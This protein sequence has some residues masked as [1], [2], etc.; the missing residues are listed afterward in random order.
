MTTVPRPER[1]ATSYDVTAACALDTLPLLAARVRALLSWGRRISLATRW[2]DGDSDITLHPGLVV[3][4]D[5]GPDAVRES[6]K[7]SE[8]GTFSVQLAPGLEGFGFSAYAADEQTTEMQVWRRWHAGDR[9]NITLVT[10]SGGM[11]GDSGPGRGDQLRIRFWNSHGVGREA[12]VGFDHH[13]YSD[14][15]RE[16]HD[17]GWDL[18]GQSID[19]A[20]CTEFAQLGRFRLVCGYPIRLGVCDGASDHVTDEIRPVLRGG[21]QS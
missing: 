11:A 17:R 19:V 9:R 10:L 14:A 3:A 6:V 12:V 8:F 5:M 4:D 20:Y 2:L 15:A 1:I 13:A 16:R 7:P 21:G 18:G